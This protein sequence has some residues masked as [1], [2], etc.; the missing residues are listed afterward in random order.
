M[1]NTNM[2]LFRDIKGEK[3]GRWTVISFDH[4]KTTAK[5]NYQYWLCRCDCGTTKVVEGMSLKKKN[6]TSCGCKRVENI[7]RGKSHYEWKGE[8]ASLSAIH[9]WLHKNYGKA[10]KCESKKC[11]R[12]SKRFEWAKIKG[13]KYAHNRDNFMML[14]RSCHALYDMT[15]E[16][17]KNVALGMKKIA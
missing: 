12:K 3:F 6:S 16:W 11:N 14:C 1:Y 4:K 2:A 5:G 8:K 9:I 10:Y 17:R 13:K 7:P 15:D